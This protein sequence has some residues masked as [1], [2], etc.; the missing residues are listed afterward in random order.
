MIRIFFTNNI[1][2]YLFFVFVKVKP[3]HWQTR[4]VRQ[5]RNF[6]AVNNSR[7]C[8]VLGWLIFVFSLLLLRGGFIELVYLGPG[9]GG[10]RG[11]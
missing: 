8:V 5:K 1:M 11:G 10:V 7:S 3:R 4:A 6:G 9:G 2:A